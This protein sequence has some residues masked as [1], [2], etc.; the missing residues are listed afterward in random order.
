MTSTSL[1]TLAAPF[2]W[3][4]AAPAVGG[5][6]D[7]HVFDFYA[8][9]LEPRFSLRRVLARVEAVRPEA[10]NVVSF[11]LRPNR[12]WRGFRA[13]QHV[14]VMVEIDGV[15]HTR[16]Y[17]P[18][19]A[20][21]DGGTITLTVKRHAAGRVSGY[22]HD[23]LGVGD[24]V[25]L[26]Q[27]FG[28]FVLPDPPPAKVL[29]MAGGS[30]ITPL[31][32]M[33]RDLLARHPA[34]DVVF[35]HYASTHR[36]VIFGGELAWLEDRHANVRV[37]FGITRCPTPPGMLSGRFSAAHLERIAPDAGDRATFVCGPY[38]FVRTVEV[39]W[40][41]RGHRERPRVERFTPGIVGP[42]EAAT[43]GLRFARSA[44][45]VRGTTDVPLLVQA[46]RAGLRPAYGCRMG[47]CRTCT[48]RMRSGAVKNLLT[49]AI[50]TEPDQ[51][52]Q[53]CISAPVSD[54]TLDL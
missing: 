14:P 30:G 18:S 16:V 32:A 31:M 35:A 49:G 1:A 24:A 15:R 21:V 4:A 53:L 8:R 45:D 28:D 25:E 42:T 51:D 47:V 43:I 9:R 20:P 7:E 11:V 40:D 6:L 2:R 23:H 27:A 38:G 12:N 50:T 22:L 5:L 46:E 34:A 41:E 37:H 44:T 19:N 39:V 48:C 52:I 3:L 29:M 36:D 54:V 33:L 26:G 13:G 10:R 17:S